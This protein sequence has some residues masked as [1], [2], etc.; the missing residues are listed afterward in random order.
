MQLIV[1][2]LV[3]SQFLPGIAGMQPIPILIQCTLKLNSK[4][5]CS[6]ANICSPG[7]RCENRFPAVTSQL[8]LGFDQFDNLG[9]SQL[10]KDVKFNGFCT[11]A[12]CI[13]LH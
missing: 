4:L 6:E 8:T 12:T 2:A 10:P 3:F 9:S 13:S 5:G 1:I 7:P 11:A